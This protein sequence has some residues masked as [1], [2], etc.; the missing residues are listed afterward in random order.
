MRPDLQKSPLL[1]DVRVRR[2]MAHAIDRQAVHDG[3]YDG[4]G[5]ITDTFVPPEAPYFADVMREIVHYPYDPRQTEQAMLEAGLVRDAEG[6]FS[7]RSGE[8]FKPDLWITAGSDGERAAAI[9]GETW[10]RA[11]IDSQPYVVPVAATRDPETRAAFPGLAT[12]GIGASEES[13]A[14]FTSAE[15]GSAANRWRGANRSGWSN[16]DVDRL[17]AAFNSTLDRAERDRQM[18]AVARVISE[19][20]PILVY[21]PNFR[22]IAFTSALHGPTTSAPA[23]LPQWNLYAWTF[24]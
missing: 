18:I 7:S 13:V 22:A 21:H 1:L 24:Q 4:Q 6:L 9:V 23:T 20:L 14:N 2:A 11:G 3:I 8:R 17:V 19:Q 10:K 5:V 15:I 16:A 12:M